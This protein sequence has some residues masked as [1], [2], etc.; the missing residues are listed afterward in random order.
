MTVAQRFADEASVSSP[1]ELR[2]SF[3][4]VVRT[5]A[6]YHDLG[7]LDPLFQEDLIRN[8]RST[9]INHCDAGTAFLLKQRAGDAALTAYSH[10]IGLPNFAA[11]K[12][13]GADFLRDT[14]PVDC[15]PP[16]VTARRS[17][18]LLAAILAEHHRTLPESAG[19]PAPTKPALS[20]LAR[21][22]A[23]S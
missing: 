4:N 11:E 8:A 5:S 1:P 15:S 16:E 10:H 13:K 12:A 14:G 22:F 21:R 18:L 7:K 9:R 6:T 17:D 19:A 23:L 2:D 3:R 20:P